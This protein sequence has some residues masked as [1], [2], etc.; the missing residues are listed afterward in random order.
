MQ[1][2]EFDMLSEKLRKSS[3]NKNKDDFDYKGFGNQIS[4]KIESKL[5]DK[6]I[7]SIEQIK[8]IKSGKLILLISQN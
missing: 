7:R 1:N 3:K 5:V 2:V 4:N 6:N 8:H